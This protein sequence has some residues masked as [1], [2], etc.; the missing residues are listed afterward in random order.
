MSSPQV[1]EAFIGDNMVNYG[2]FLVNL[3][4]AGV[5]TMIYAGEFDSQDG[6]KS[7]EPWL[8]TLPFTGSDE[9]WDSGR[10]IYWVPTPTEGYGANG[11]INGG[12]YRTNGVF[13]FLTVPKAGH[14]VP[15]NYYP[16][17]YLFINDFVKY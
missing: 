6:A 1:H 16:P 15:A 17:S 5:P 7:C 12:L 3:V 8:R 13:T 14:F 11:F 4:D 9:F 10:Q 2:E